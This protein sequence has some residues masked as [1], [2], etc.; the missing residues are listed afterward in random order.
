MTPLEATDAFFTA[1]RDARDA[2]GPFYVLRASILGG[3]AGRSPRL[4]ACVVV[5]AMLEVDWPLD[6]I[7]GPLQVRFERALE[8][9]VGDRT[10]NAP[11]AV[12]EC[13]SEE[14]LPSFSALA[15]DV[16]ARLG[17]TPVRPRTVADLVSEWETL[18][19]ATRSL[20]AEEEVG[21]WGELCLIDQAADP[22]AALR[23]WVGPE[24]RAMDFQAGAVTVECKTSMRKLLHTFSLSQADL[25]TTCPTAYV[26]SLWVGVNADGGLSLVD[27]VERIARRLGDRF[28][29]EKKLLSW[30]FSRVDRER[31]RRRF[32][33]LEQPAVLPANRIPR[34]RAI[35]EGVLHVRYEAQLDGRVALSGQEAQQLLRALGQDGV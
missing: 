13:S 20:T 27:L 11:A 32:A 17:A 30:G 9:E 10:W 16:L 25:G 24:R 4:N 29:F 18:F 26:A 21:L 28:L 19:H 3:Y 6:R 7:S 31:Y 1:I 33:L 35:D 15:A 12:L 23:A 22:D 5:P 14:L 34:V 2:P 8:F